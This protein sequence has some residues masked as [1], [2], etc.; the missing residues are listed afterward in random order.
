MT[1]V[2]ERRDPRSRWAYL[3]TVRSRVVAEEA[4]NLF[5]LLAPPMEY[6]LEEHQGGTHEQEQRQVR[7]GP[8][9]CFG[10]DP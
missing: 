7:S 2:Y 9:A 4:V 5:R 10:C 8:R 3:G 1:S 6:R